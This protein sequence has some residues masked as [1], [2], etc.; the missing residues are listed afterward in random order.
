MTNETNDLLNPVVLSDLPIADISLVPTP[1]TQDQLQRDGGYYQAQKLLERMLDAGLIS[2][3]EFNKITALNRES[4]SP[5]LVEIF[6][7]LT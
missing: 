7:K 6:P 5:F 1:P 2:L 4:F 3:S